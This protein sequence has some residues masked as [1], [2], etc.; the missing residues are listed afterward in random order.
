MKANINPNKTQLLEQFNGKGYEVYQ[1][2]TGDLAIFSYL[3]V[4]NGSALVIDPTIET[5]EYQEIL[6]KTKAT[7]KYVVLTHFHADFVAGH[8]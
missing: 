1:F 7:I 5:S 6:S 2:K 8:L 4:S 3:I